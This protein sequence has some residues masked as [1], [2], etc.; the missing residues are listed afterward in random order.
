MFKARLDS[1][2]IFSAVL[3]TRSICRI[4]WT[5]LGETRNLFTK[6]LAVHPIVSFLRNLLC[7]LRERVNDRNLLLRDRAYDYDRFG[8]DPA[9]LRHNSRWCTQYINTLVYNGLLA[10][11]QDGCFPTRSRY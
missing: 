11:I 6:F 2:S 4:W 1:R 5:N 3:Y 7:S 10:G 9:Q 8:C